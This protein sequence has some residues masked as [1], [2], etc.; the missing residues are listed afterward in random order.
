LFIFQSPNE[1]ARRS[2]FKQGSLKKVVDDLQ[3]HLEGQTEQSILK[4][5]LVSFNL[6]QVRKNLDDHQEQ[7][8]RNN[9]AFEFIHK[10]LQEY[11]VAELIWKTF[12]ND[13]LKEDEDGFTLGVEE[14]AYKLFDLL[15]PRIITREIQEYIFDLA[16]SEAERFKGNPDLYQRLRKVHFLL[17][18]YDFLL[19]FDAKTNEMPS[20]NEHASPLMKQLAVFNGCITVLGAIVECIT[21]DLEVPRTHEDTHAKFIEEQCSKYSFIHSGNQIHLVLLF[22]RIYSFQ[23]KMHFQDLGVANLS[24]ADLRGGYLRGANLIVAD[25]RG[26]Y[27]ILADL[28]GAYLSVANL[29][30]AYLSVANLRGAYLMGADLR[31]ADLS[32]TNLRGADLRGAYLMGADLRKADLSGTNL[33]GADLSEVKFS[34]PDGTHPARNLDKALN[35]NSAKNKH[36]AHWKGTIYEGKFNTEEDTI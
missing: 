1:Y 20:K 30:G 29:R 8:E 33:R 28:R 22:K 32:G 4:D 2:D 12:T 7:D 27:L 36:L 9:Y 11:L 18:E 23:L 24:G 19:H 5:L 34:N 21:R 6:R 35:L 31:K 13:C 10:S 26:A 25:L 3:D 15:S 17:A 16:E 14:A